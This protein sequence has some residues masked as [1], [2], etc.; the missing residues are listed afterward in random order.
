MKKFLIV[1]LTILLLLTSCE[2]ITKQNKSQRNVYF[3]SLALDY[4]Y[5]YNNTLLGTI[6]D[7]KSL[8]EEIKYL[9]YCDNS[10]FSYYLIKQEGEMVEINSNGSITNEILDSKK[11]IYLI[12]DLIISKLSAYS[13]V[14]DENDLLIFQYS[15][16]G[17]DST[18]D[19]VCYYDYS[20]MSLITSNEIIES[21]KGNNGIKLLIIDSCYSGKFYDETSV[22]Y[23]KNSFK[24]LF[25][26]IQSRRNI[27][28]ITAASSDELAYPYDTSSDTFGKLTK[29]FLEVLGYDTKSKTVGKKNKTIWY[30]DLVTQIQKTINNNNSTTPKQHPQG[31]EIK[32]FILF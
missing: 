24:S 8:F 21:I 13:S 7:Q 6:N 15:G 31:N 3:I 4:N 14:M 9:A 5:S 18:G 23:N 32:D 26:S 27:F 1:L 28:A 22:E 2:L 12:K 25:E 29:C 30:S 11:H 19:L 16:H 10:P 17:L 20:S